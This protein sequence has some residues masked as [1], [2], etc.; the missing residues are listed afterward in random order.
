MPT[1]T[2]APAPP[3]T[4]PRPLQ[5][6]VKKVTKGRF[7]GR[8]LSRRP[9]LKLSSLLVGLG[10]LLALALLLLTSQ[11]FIIQPLLTSIIPSQPNLTILEP[12]NATVTA[13]MTVGIDQAAS[14]SKYIF[15]SV[16]NTA[17]KSSSLAQAPTANKVLASTNLS[18]A[19]SGNH[20]VNGSGSTV[21]LHGVNRSGTEYACFQFGISDGPLDDASV[22]A[23]ASWGINV[24]RIPLNEDCWLGING[25]PKFSTTAQYQQAIVNYVN[26]LNAHGIYAWLD[27]QM[28][29]PAAD[30]STTILPMPD[31]DH[32]PAFWT[33][34]ANTFK[35][36]PA[37][38]FDLYNEPHD[39]PWSCWAN[40]CQVTSGFNFVHAY[41]A[42]GMSQLVSTIRSTGATNVINVAGLSWSYDLGGWLANRPNDNQLIAGVHNYGATG[43]NTQANW[44]TLYTPVSQQVPVVWGEMGEEDCASTYINQAM[45]WADSRGIGYLAWTWDTWGTCEAL[46]SNYNGTPTNYGSGLK[47]HLATL[48]PPAPSPTPPPPPAPSPLP[49]NTGSATMTFSVATA[50]QYTVWSR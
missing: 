31:T 10:S 23:M 3:P 48:A 9:V 44:D 38:V 46:I 33:S 20:L 49:T 7:I 45:P 47:A 21:H 39:V 22:T 36:N 30:Q 11:K 25:F 50:G 32:A 24:V 37:V 40:G 15:T 34:I 41:Q 29:A 26:T 1:R 8:P 27:L 13:P 4:K 14:G 28:V 43:F 18:L 42:A 5:D 2:P 6:F 35:A 12:E 17:A 16:T 19:V